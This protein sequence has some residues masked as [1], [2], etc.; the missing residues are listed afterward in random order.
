MP[1]TF[2]ALVGSGLRVAG[3]TELFLAYCFVADEYQ[4]EISNFYIVFKDKTVIDFNK[5]PLI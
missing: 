4:K 1:S 3:P 5:I 2:A